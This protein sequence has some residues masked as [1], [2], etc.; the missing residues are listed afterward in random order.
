MSSLFRPQA[1]MLS[2][3]FSLTS[4]NFIVVSVFGKGGGGECFLTVS[5]TVFNLELSYYFIHFCDDSD[6]EKNCM[7]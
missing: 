4:V 5:S 2:A 6:G 7:H 3:S 1:V